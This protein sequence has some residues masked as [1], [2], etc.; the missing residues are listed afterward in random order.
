MSGSRPTVAIRVTAENADKTRTDLERIGTSGEAAMRRVQNASAAA[1]PEMQR[2]AGASDIAQ[3]AFIGLGASSG[4]LG[5]ALSGLAS[6]GS[7]AGAAVAGLAAGLGAAVTVAEKFERLSLR[8]E[9][10]VRAT[11]GAAGI[12]A[13]EIRGLSQEIARSTLASTAGVEAAAG[14]LLTFRSV[15][16]ETFARTLRA[17]Q[18]LAE[19]GFGTLDSTIVQLGKAL[20]TPRQGMSALAEAGVTFLPVQ[21]EVIAAL[22]ETGNVAEA[23]RRIL[24]AVEQQVGGTGEA[25]SKGLAGAYDTLG[26]NVEEF[27]ARIGNTGPLQAAALAINTLAAAVSGL[28]ALYDGARNLVNPNELSA[29]NAR[30]AAADR[31]FQAASAN[32]DPRDPRSQERIREVHNDLMAALM[33]RQAIIDKADAERQARQDAAASVRLQSERESAAATLAVI[34]Q[35]LIPR[36]KLEEDHRKRLAAIARSA[37]LGLIDP[38]ERTRMETLANEQLAKA[39]EGTARAHARVAK[40]AADADAHVKAYLKDQ[41]DAAKAVEEAQKKAAREIERFHERSFDSVANIGER[42]FERIGDA[43]V[44]AMLAGEGRAVNLG[45]VLRGVA[46]SVAADFARLALVNPLLNSVFTSSSGPR[47]TLAGAFG[48]S[49]TSLGGFGGLGGITSFLPAGGL[50]GMMA[51]ANSYLFGTTAGP[52]AEVTSGL[53]G[54][55]GTMSLGA[56]GAGF[57]TGMFAN[58]L[59][60]GNQVGGTIG[61]GVGSLAGMALGS[62]IGMPFLGAMLGGALGGAGGGMFGP[63]PSVQAWS[64]GLRAAD[65][66]PAF[67]DAF[68]SQLEMDNVFFN[69]SGA[70]QFQAANASIAQI[71]EFLAARG[72]TVRGARAVSG[73][74]RGPDGVGAASFNDAFATFQFGAQDNAGLAAGLSGRSFGDPAALQAFV[75]GFLEIEA[76]IKALTADAVPAF[77]AS[78]TAVNDNFAA[79]RDRATELGVSLDGLTEAQARAIGELEDA[80]TEQLRASSASLEVRRL[81][82]T[83]MGQDA[84][85]LAQAE[86]ASAELRSFSDALDAMAITAEDKANRLVQL[87]EVQAA[88]RAAIV[89][90]WG[91]QTNAALRQGLQSGQSLMRDLAFG[92]ASPL[93]PEQQFFAAMTTLNQA[94]QD[95]DA[96]GSLSDYTSIA[97]QVLPV[98]RDFLGTSQR[99]GGLVA[100][101]GQVLSSQGADGA[102]LSQIMAAQVNSTDAMGATLASLGARQVDELIG[103]RR[104]LGRLSSAVEAIISRQQ[105][106]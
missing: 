95:L 29:A 8:T 74:N 24:E 98:A 21:R 81:R 58:S 91:E 103:L 55:G 90:R 96:G 45:N 102:G 33:E 100:E 104:D 52:L 75:D 11:G 32:A 97:S 6:A 87:E 10:V 22:A 36:E 77:T 27:L 80:R 56:L 78:I 65:P 1:T 69:E 105:A 64:Y 20:E 37:D 34:R 14:K 39:L 47:A 2:L 53:L 79:V 38:A 9:A 94:R 106:A 62:M 23:Q 13:A 51:S 42:A 89:A 54:S 73:N 28:N 61:S 30:V 57:G 41:A 4:Q 15:A 46:A 40:E 31:R 101:I 16:G 88:E 86:A 71:N 63:G 7:V 76:V 68:G 99:Y 43:A 60:G 93:A 72:L 66:N 82:A 83:G 44:N 35:G 3:R 48:G 25:A 19:A 70:Q 85:L 84:D 12:S 67:G 26:Q 17:A 59:L 18:D 50:S 92:A 49:A 5:A